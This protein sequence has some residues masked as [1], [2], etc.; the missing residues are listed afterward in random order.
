MRWSFNRLA[1]CSTTRPRPGT[2]ASTGTACRPE[3]GGEPHGDLAAAIQRDFGSFADFQQA[4]SEAAVKLFGSGW[5][6]LAADTAGK[7]Q[8]VPLGNA[9]TPL[10]HGK[11]PVLT[12][13]L[14]EHAYYIDFRNER[15]KIRRWFLG[16]CQLGLRR[17]V[18]RCDREVIPAKPA[19]PLV[20]LRGR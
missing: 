3:G 5:A 12:I 6:W 2:T 8:I 17:K 9:D 1:R 7:L 11:E 18:L 4:M 13:D 16:G 20:R 10:K 19:Q 15:A 14:W